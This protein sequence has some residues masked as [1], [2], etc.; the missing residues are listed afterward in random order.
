[1]SQEIESVKKHELLVNEVMG[2]EYGHFLSH[3]EI[4]EII[5]ERVASGKYYAIVK[6]ANKLLEHEGKMIE[7]IHGSGYR[8]VEPREYV[9]H[10]LKKTKQS[11]R[12]LRKAKEILDYAPVDD[13]TD[14]ERRRHTRVSDQMVIL[15]AQLTGGVTTVRRL[16]RKEHPLLPSNRIRGL[17]NGSIA[18]HQSAGV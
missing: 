12:T 9:S 2:K 3:Q 5:D 6:K 1:M 17:E 4:G 11:A 16:A 10:S 15:E 8:V 13:M 14:E 18:P 7:S